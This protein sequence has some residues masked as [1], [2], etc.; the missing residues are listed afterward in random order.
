MA[1]QGVAGSRLYDQTV[2][3]WHDIE[4]S[5][6]AFANRVRGFLDAHTHKTIATELLDGAPRISG[7]EAWIGDGDLWFGSMPNARKA[8]DLQRDP[9]YA[10]HSGSAN[11]PEWEATRS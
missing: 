9:R 2:A 8:V 10:L 4:E 7:I 5:S 1:A 11:P 3:R 6:P